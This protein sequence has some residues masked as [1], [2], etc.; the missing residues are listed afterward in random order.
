MTRKHGKTKINMR[1]LQLFCP[2]LGLNCRFWYSRIQISQDRSA[3]ELQWQPVFCPVLFS[4]PRSRLRQFARRGFAVSGKPTKLIS[5]T[6]RVRHFGSL[7]L[8]RNK[9]FDQSNV[10]NH[11]SGLELSEGL[12]PFTEKLLE[13]WIKDISCR[14]ARSKK[15][16]NWP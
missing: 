13:I 4:Y 14:V 9:H 7:N 6:V 8:R 16:Q 1:K 2:Y 12:R 11:S 3:W 5:N 10:L 15:D